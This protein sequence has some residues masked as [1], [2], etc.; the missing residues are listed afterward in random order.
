MS[1]NYHDVEKVVTLDNFMLKALFKDGT[2][3]IYDMKPI[4][5]CDSTTSSQN[6]SFY[7]LLIEKPETFRRAYVTPDGSI[8]IWDRE[9]DLSA[10]AIWY[11]G[12]T[13]GSADWTTEDDIASAPCPIM[14][15]VD[16]TEDMVDYV[17]LYLFPTDNEHIMPY[18]DAYYDT[19]AASYA[20]ETGECLAGRLPDEAE[21]PFKQWLEQNRKE[22]LRVWKEKQDQEK[23]H[24]KTVP[25]RA[26][27]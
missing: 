25:A 6:K 15:Y 11:D 2:V 1:S 3:K 27:R 18:L 7:N 20:V 8:V 4:I 5:Y 22:V 12:I 23:Y 24:P 14:F 17:D 10:E 13:L 26:V 21:I 16:K 19:S 9:T